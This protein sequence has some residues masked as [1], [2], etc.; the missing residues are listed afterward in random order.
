MADLSKEE[1]QEVL[2]L[3]KSDEVLNHILKE[4]IKVAK[5]LDELRFLVEFSR[6]HFHLPQDVLDLLGKLVPKYEGEVSWDRYTK[7][8]TE[9]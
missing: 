4:E 1:L 9:D 5:K 3:M 8:M 2:D 6:Q 7:L